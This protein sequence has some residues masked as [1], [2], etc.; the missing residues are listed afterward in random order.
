MSKYL[1]IGCISKRGELMVGIKRWESCP[2]GTPDGS[3]GEYVDLAVLDVI[4]YSC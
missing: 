1:Y 3:Q 4:A 2:A